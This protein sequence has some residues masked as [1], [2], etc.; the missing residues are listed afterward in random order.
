MEAKNRIYLN[1]YDMRAFHLDNSWQQMLGV[2]ATEEQ[3]DT[4]TFICNFEDMVQRIRDLKHGH[5]SDMNITY[6]GSGTP[7]ALKNSNTFTVKLNGAIVLSYDLLSANYNTI[8]KLGTAVNTLDNWTVTLQGKNDLSSSLVDFNEVSFTNQILNVFSE[9]TQYDN[10][11]D[12]IEAGDAILT[13]KW[14]LY[15]V[16]NAQPFGNFG[17]DYVEWKLECG[18]ARLDQVNLPANYAEEI[19]ENQYNLKQKISME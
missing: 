13:N 18:L 4:M 6:S 10:V 19:K 12:V 3:E 9:D 7:S 11:T 2:F 14:R 8:R 16:R 15:E 1:P 5:I 17:W